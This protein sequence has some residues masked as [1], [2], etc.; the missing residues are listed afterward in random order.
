MKRVILPVLH[1]IL[2]TAIILTCL[3]LSAW[4]A[5]DYVVEKEFGSFMADVPVALIQLDADKM[6]A[7]NPEI[8][9]DITN[10]GNT[11]FIRRKIED[12]NGYSKTDD[13]PYD[14][15]VYNPSA[16]GAV[17]L[18][19]NSTLLGYKDVKEDQVVFSFTIPEAA[20]LPDG[21]RVNVVLS[22]SNVRLQLR[23]DASD[24]FKEHALFS[25]VPL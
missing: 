22:Y 5:S 17:P 4:A 19:P 9:I 15:V 2:L 13:S 1:L 3:P 7:S 16:N 20:I 6:K 21:E 23:P 11:G 14:F 8:K 12:F 18:G 25:S 24:D 10:E